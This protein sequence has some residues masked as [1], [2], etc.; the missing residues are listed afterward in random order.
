MDD[1]FA[2][3]TKDI[4]VVVSDCFGDLHVCTVHGSESQ[5]T[6]QHEFHVSCSG[7]LFGSKADLLR[8]IAGRDHHFSSRDVVVF[9]KDELH[10]FG[11]FRVILDHLRKGEE[12]MDDVFGDDICRS[13]FGTKDTYQRNGRCVTG[14]DLQIL[15]DQEQKIQLLAF[16]LVKSFGL[17]RKHGICI[18]LYA[19]FLKKPCGKSLFVLFLDLGELLK[20]VLVICICQEFLQF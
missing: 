3:L 19:L 5:G 7:C 20:Y 16:I 14:F 8:E 6:V 17:D 10:P 11:N 18:K 15:M 13:C 4:D 9:Y 12:S 2:A 1:L